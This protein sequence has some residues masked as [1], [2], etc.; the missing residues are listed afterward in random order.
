[1]K[2]HVSVPIAKYAKHI[3]EEI[4]N[5][6]I[7]CD[8][9]INTFMTCRCLKDSSDEMVKVS[10]SLKERLP[11]KTS[12]FI[13]AITLSEF[14]NILFICSLKEK[15]DDGK[16]TEL[17]SLISTIKDLKEYCRLNGVVFHGGINILNITAEDIP[18]RLQQSKMLCGV[19]F[20]DKNT[21]GRNDGIVSVKNTIAVDEE[22]NFREQNNIKIPDDLAEQIES[23]TQYAMDVYDEII[24]IRDVPEVYKKVVLDLVD[25]ITHNIE[26]NG[27]E[28]ITVGLAFNPRT[29]LI[30]AL[31]DENIDDL[32]KHGYMTKEARD[33]MIQFKKQYEEENEKDDEEE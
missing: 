23:I 20:I 24:G 10:N 9:I 26:E 1:M 5:N 16:E 17:D 25:N 29:G 6:F 7:I 14:C 21:F 2:I 31:T 11:N 12:F 28:S 13:D 18:E 33:S 3:K 32:Y 30:V 15:S 22:G 27:N 8:D 4:T 19:H